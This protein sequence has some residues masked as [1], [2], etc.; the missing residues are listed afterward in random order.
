M[1]FTDF[2]QCGILTDWQERQAIELSLLSN[3]N[4]FIMRGSLALH[5]E[6]LQPFI[7]NSKKGNLS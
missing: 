4:V 6:N 1:Y 5:A 3:I 2:E 7:T